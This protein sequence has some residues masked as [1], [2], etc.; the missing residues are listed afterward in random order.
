MS[1]CC[2]K[3]LRKKIKKKEQNRRKKKYIYIECEQWWLPTQIISQRGRRRNKSA[4]TPARVREGI[5]VIHFPIYRF[6]CFFFSLH[7]L[8]FSFFFPFF[9]ATVCYRLFLRFRKEEK[10]ANNFDQKLSERR[11]LFQI[12]KWESIFFNSTNKTKD[13]KTRLIPQKFLK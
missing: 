1:F 8:F 2:K 12:L 9:L 11:Y 6:F 5:P 4:S 7:F 3:N 10:C 13:I